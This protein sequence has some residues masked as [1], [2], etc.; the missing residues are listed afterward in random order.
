[1]SVSEGSSETPAAPTASLFDNC[2]AVRIFSNHYIDLLKSLKELLSAFSPLL[3]P[4]YAKLFANSKLTHAATL[5]ATPTP[6]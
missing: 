1:M 4:M 6:S 2:P 5:F 3:T